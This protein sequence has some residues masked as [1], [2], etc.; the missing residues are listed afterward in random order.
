MHPTFVM[1]ITDRFEHAFEHPRQVSAVQAARMALEDA[2]GRVETITPPE[3]ID[4]PTVRT[5]RLH[6]LWKISGI[7]IVATLFDQ[8]LE[9]FP[10]LGQEVVHTFD[11]RDFQHVGLGTTCSVVDITQV[12]R[13]QQSLDRVGP[14]TGK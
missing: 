2:L 5:K 13:P 1:S 11:T 7:Q 4:A 10:L 3:G 9:Y 8:L 14:L 6:G 12:S